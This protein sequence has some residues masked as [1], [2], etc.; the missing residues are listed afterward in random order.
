MCTPWTLSK[1][2]R[3]RPCFS[4]YDS[5]SSR[6]ES[7]TETVPSAVATNAGNGSTVN[8]KATRR[9]VFRGEQIDA[10]LR[11]TQVGLPDKARKYEL[12]WHRGFEDEHYIV[13]C[14]GEEESVDR[15]DDSDDLDVPPDSGNDSGGLNTVSKVIIPSLLLFV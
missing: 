13:L 1:L 9:M 12:H 5:P 11:S 10:T 7:E 3:C 4:Q 14:F 6:A 15:E 2:I 8:R